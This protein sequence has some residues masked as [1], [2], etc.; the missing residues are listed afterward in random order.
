MKMSDL[1]ILSG[2]DTWLYGHLLILYQYH[3]HISLD[4]EIHLTA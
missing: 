1:S 4:L 3:L 2:S